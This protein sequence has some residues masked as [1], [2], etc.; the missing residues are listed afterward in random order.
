MRPPDRLR[1]PSWRV[2]IGGAILVLVVFA[3]DE[4][5]GLAER[6]LGGAER[7]VARHSEFAIEATAALLVTG[8]AAGIYRRL[9]TR[10]R[11]LSELL[12]VCAWCRRV[13]VDGRWVTIEEFL[14]SDEEGR[15]TVSLC[16]ACYERVHARRGTAAS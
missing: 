6:L 16:A 12:T 15:T 2:L 7:S 3:L 10:E 9:S 1:R 11:T 5:G 13:A 14:N 4:Y 8:L